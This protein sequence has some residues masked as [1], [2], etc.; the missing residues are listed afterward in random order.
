MRNKFLNM[1]SKIKLES[2]NE[3]EMTLYVYG[4]I[5]GWENSA[6]RILEQLKESKAETIHVHINSGGGSAFDGV[7][8]CNLLKNHKAKIVAYVDG[9]AASAASII[10]MGADEIIMP[11]NTMMMI[12]EASTFAYG[13]ADWFD[14]VAGDLRKVTKAV[15]AS[16]KNRFVGTDEELAKM[17]KKEEWLTAEE[18]LALGFADKITDEI[19]FEEPIQEDDEPENIKDDLVAK[20]SK[21]NNEPPEPK[22]PVNNISRLFF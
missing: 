9:W 5:G 17:L 10:A 11:S 21:Q 8:I 4:Y 12:H 18:A 6:R 16:Y 15:S 14:K 19:E 7:A 20:Y 22:E 13:N 2:K 1:N 3:K